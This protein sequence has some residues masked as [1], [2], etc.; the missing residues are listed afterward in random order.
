MNVM[1][2]G[3]LVCMGAAMVS[4]A[5]F[6]LVSRLIPE[7]WLAADSDAASALYATIGMVYAILIALAAIAV[8]EPRSAAAGSTEQEAAT[9]AE[10]YWVANGLEA[11]D[12]S[13]IQNL[14][15]GYLEEASTDEWENLAVHQEPGAR[16]AELFARLRRSADTVDTTTDRAQ[17]AQQ[18]LSSYLSQAASAR[19][20]RVGAA[21]EGMPDLLWWVLILGGLVSVGFLYLFGLETTFPNGL[22]MAIVGGMIALMLFVLYQVEFPFSRAFA[23][24]PEALESALAQLH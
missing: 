1:L 22:M 23:V 10:A 3:G 2:A 14:I 11:P 4:A 8:W 16:A 19:L 12:K 5:G 7:R 21:G 15:H 18:Q 9:L 13:N 17:N 6:V 20:A 24:G